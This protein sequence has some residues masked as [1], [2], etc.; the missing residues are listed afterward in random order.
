MTP[1]ISTAHHLSL[2][3]PEHCPFW[4]LLGVGGGHAFRGVTSES[5]DWIFGYNIPGQWWIKG[6]KTAWKR[7]MIWMRYGWRERWDPAWH[8][9]TTRQSAG[10]Y[11]GSQALRAYTPLVTMPLYMLQSFWALQIS[12]KEGIWIGVHESPLF[13]IPSTIL[14][15]LSAMSSPYTYGLAYEPPQ[16]ISIASWNS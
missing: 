16:C 11:S 2:T 12:M 3:G 7:D 13:G 9:A 1:I 15:V 5:S 14:D 8:G 4:G 6:K 10:L